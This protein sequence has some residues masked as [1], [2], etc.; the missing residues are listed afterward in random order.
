VL[1][2]GMIAPIAPF[3]IRGAIW[4]QGES[5]VN[6]RALY[7]DLQKTLIEDWRALWN[8][9]EM[10]FYFVQLA[11]HKAPAKEPT[12]S[13][14]AEMR[15]A[16]AGS[17]T[18]PHTGM[19][20]TID[21]GDEKNVHPGNKLDVGLRLARLALVGTYQRAG[22][23]SGPMFRDAKVEG[24]TVR[25]RFDHIGSGL[26]AKGGA[27]GQFAI[28]GADRKFIWAQAKIDGDSVVVS[29]PTVPQPAFV[30]YAWADNPVG[31][32][33]TNSAGLPAAPFRTDR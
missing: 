22:I 3:A 27:L 9:P 26:M 33:L 21:I 31:A 17:L 8:Q 25:V 11:A 7:P 5:N 30:R 1:H 4:Y 15:E 18:I 10:P 2:N 20:V 28:S 29:S 13:Q 24:T 16:Q 12:N 32:N 23:S 19:A 14:L 6:S